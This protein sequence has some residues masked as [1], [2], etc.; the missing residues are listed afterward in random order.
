MLTDTQE[1]KVLINEVA[2][3]IVGEKAPQELPLYVTSRNEYFA[4]PKRFTEV[5]EAE[6]EPLGIGATIAVTMLTKA[7]FP[8]LNPIL[9][10]LL[11]AVAE[12]L[13]EEGAEQASN[14]IRSLFKDTTP[15]PVFTQEQLE[16]I[17]ST[18]QTI[19]H[20]EAER[21]GIEQSQARTVSD[22][23]IARLALTKM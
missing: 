4:D 18:I 11:D 13:K 7:V 15:K 22:A 12:A 6:D 14:W 17:A 2:Y 9:S 19:A 20:T 3:R 10:Y 21:L 1:G 5:V 16:V 8:I 23:V